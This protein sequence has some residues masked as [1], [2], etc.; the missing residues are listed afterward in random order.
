[1]KL[2]VVAF[3]VLFVAWAQEPPDMDTSY[4]N[5][6]KALADKNA[7]QVKKL[8]AE[9]EAAAKQVIASQSS[10]ADQV[11][12]A[13]E[14]QAYAEYALYTMA[15]GAPPE[16]AVD[17]LAT[18]EQ[19]NPKSK[20]MDEGYAY[21]FAILNK[22]G[23]TAK[24][25]AIAEKAIANFPGNEDL[26]MILAN[27]AMERKQNDRAL[28]YADR[29]VAAVNKHP[30]PEGMSAGDWEKKKST[31]LGQGYY[32]AGMVH[33]VKNQFPEA[34]KD[35]RAALPYIKD[36]QT[37][38]AYA[39]FQLGVAN[40]NIGKVYLN[41]AQMMEGAKYSEQSGMI[42]SPVQEQAKRNAFMI[43]K[44]ATGR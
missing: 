11:K 14:V 28:N 34:N 44:E 13:K 37:M 42:Q 16:T 24:I 40:Y 4:Q 19:Q 9:T 21:Y 27:T 10:Q 30:K 23:A 38:M 17:L 12:Y 39:L 43:R 8:A 22:T 5:L 41:T 20:Y 18:L 7:A 25:P 15:V 35:L 29:L 31:A 2:S 1:M 3:A 36:N 32:I 26:L 6:Q 33:A